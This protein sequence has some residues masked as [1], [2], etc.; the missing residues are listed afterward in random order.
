M[1]D[2]LV[3][4]HDS[5]TTY[6]DVS[7]D[8]IINASSVSKVANDSDL[9]CI[10]GAKSSKRYRLSSLAHKAKAKTKG[11]FKAN[12]E[13][14]ATDHV[15]VF[16][17]AISD[18]QRDPAFNLNL[19]G[20]GEHASACS[21]TRKT[22]G[23]LKS[24]HNTLIHPKKA[25]KSKITKSTAGQ[26]SKAER[27]YLSKRADL[28]LLEAHDDLHRAQSTC[29][30][31]PDMSVEEQ[32]EIIR[33]HRNKINEMENHR[34]GLR[35]AWTT[36]RHVRRVR[37]VPKRHIDF[38]TNAY[39]AKGGANSQSKDVRGLKWLG[40]NL[41]Y[42]TQDFC[43]QYID[44]FDELPFD[45]DSSRHYVE[46]IIMASAPWQSW[47]MD[48]RKVYRWEDPKRTAR[49]CFLFVLLWYTEHVLGFFWG[50]ILYMVLKNRYYPTSA[51]SLRSAMQRAHDSKGTAFKFGEL[52]DKHGRSDW[53]EPAMAQLG[54]AFQL[55]LGDIAN[56]L[57]VFSNFYN[58]KSPRKTAAT[59]YFFLSCLLVS[60]VADMRFCIKIVWFV[61]GGA[62]FLC[63][64]IASRYPNYRYLVSPPKWVFWDIPTH[65]EWSFQYLRRQA[66]EAREQLILE[67]VISDNSQAIAQPR[68]SGS[69]ALTPRIEITKGRA[70]DKDLIDDSD[71]SWFYS[72]NS[73]ASVLEPTD[74][75]SFNASFEG[76]VG[77]F[78]IFTQGIRFVCRS[79]I[80]ELWS[81]K[82]SE[83]VEMLKVEGTRTSKFSSSADQLEIRCTNRDQLNLEGMKERDEAFNTVIAFS[84]LQWQ[85][86]Q[87]R[88]DRSN[89]QES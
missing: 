3:S 37:V 39:H 61:V 50:Y 35:A 18:I 6:H 69:L 10:D 65:A 20:E 48:V 9:T 15:P 47:V 72:A 63:F 68:R 1:N 78:V 31:R 74:I 33:R 38:S 16:G 41:L 28:D 79:K 71:D 44:D 82:F 53:L 46:R 25:M 8:G 76:T 21:G 56:M 27:P 45:I 73:T 19:L 51:E 34:E 88:Q 2:E 87:I 7:D 4:P 42:Y 13:H 52:I 84:S 26:L 67:Q 64:P 85:S 66:Q 55:Q 62:F 89:A 83:L 81:Y 80:S 14:T 36:S 5:S 29:S 32:D 30:S 43:A 22:S 59:L 77:R 23:T 58:W 86:L 12:D 54:P 75:R 40:A 24:L 57:E 49:W 17:S 60:L 11:M 70:I